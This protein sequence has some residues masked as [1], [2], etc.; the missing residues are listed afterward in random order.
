MKVCG[1]KKWTVNL[2]GTN[3][4]SFAPVGKSLWSFQTVFEGPDDSSLYFCNFYGKVVIILLFF[5]SIVANMEEGFLG[6][7]SLMVI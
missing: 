7:M 5:S 2:F 3:F 1:G 6:C 4:G